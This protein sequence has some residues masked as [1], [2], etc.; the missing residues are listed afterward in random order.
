MNN[1][2]TAEE[3]MKVIEQMENIERW[4][5]LNELYDEFYNKGD[6]PKSEI[7]FDY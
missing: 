5:L 2:K 6:F 3:V 4:K 7:D 1:V